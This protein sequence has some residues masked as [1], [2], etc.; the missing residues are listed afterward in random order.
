MDDADL[1]YEDL[2]EDLEDGRAIIKTS[3][4]EMEERIK[5]LRNE[6]DQ[7]SLRVRNLQEQNDKLVKQNEV[8]TR[9]ISCLFKTAQMEIACKD[10]QIR[11]LQLESISV[12]APNHDTP[13]SQSSRGAVAGKW[14]PDTDVS[15]EGVKHGD[16][17]NFHSSRGAPAAKRQPDTDVGHEAR[18]HAVMALK[19]KSNE[20]KTSLAANCAWKQ[21]HRAGAQHHE[22]VEMISIC[23]GRDSVDETW[24]RRRG[25]EKSWQDHPNGRRRGNEK[26]ISGA[27]EREDAHQHLLNAH[28][29]LKSNGRKRATHA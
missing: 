9:N 18:K 11:S 29:G 22:S 24:K 2:F 26:Y 16:T 17:P 19:D 13:N 6:A 27:R 8:L 12:P 7:L 28:G 10:K 3:V 1:L 23:K 20:N 15:R 4:H 25:D 5:E 14:Q 21:A